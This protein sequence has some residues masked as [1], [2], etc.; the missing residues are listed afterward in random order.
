VDGGRPASIGVSRRPER[1][2]SR[3]IA[4]PRDHSL[5][6]APAAYRAFLFCC[7]RKAHTG[8]MEMRAIW[9]YINL[10]WRS[11]SVNWSAPNTFVDAATYS[12]ERR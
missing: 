8:S 6:T 9:S 4:C 12:S 7:Y 11:N 10:T 5:T 3:G 1:A 2:V